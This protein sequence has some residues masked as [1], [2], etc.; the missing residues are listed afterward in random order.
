MG[1]AAVV[2]LAGLSYEDNTE[3]G[4]AYTELAEAVRVRGEVDRVYLDAPDLLQ[5]RRDGP[6]PNPES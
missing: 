5:L 3:G 2:G 1:T 4:A 6:H